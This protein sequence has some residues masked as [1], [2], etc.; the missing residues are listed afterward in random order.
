[1]KSQK[2][3]L[4]EKVNP[5]KENNYYVTNCPYC[6]K[7]FT[8]HKIKQ[9]M[10]TCKIQKN[11]QK[12]EKLNNTVPQKDKHLETKQKENPRKTFK[13]SVTQRR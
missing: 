10:D 11:Q 13:K 4:S 1:M 3:K 6:K 12:K 9:H 7:Q 8:P 5:Q 2:I